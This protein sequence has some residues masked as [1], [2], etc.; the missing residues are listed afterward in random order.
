MVKLF[1]W[2]RRIGIAVIGLLLFGFFG[3]T[4]AMAEE[5]ISAESYVLMEAET[6]RV[7]SGRN[8]TEK[9][10]MAST[11][12][13]MTTLLVLEQPQLD[14]A[15]TVNS[16]EVKIEGSSMGLLPGDSVTLRDLCYGMMLPSGN[17]AANAAAVRIAGSTEEFAKMMNERAGEMGMESTNFVTPSGLHNEEHYST[18][19]DMALLAREALKNPDFSEIC[20]TAKAKRSFGNPP[21]QRWMTNHNK[22]LKYYEGCIGLKTGFTKKAGRCLVSAAEREG[23]TL[24]CVTLNAPSD[25]RDH[26]LLFDYG[27]SSVKQVMLTP[28]LTG[29]SLGIVGANQNTISVA[30]PEDISA[31]LTEEEKSR[32]IQKILLPQFVYAPV[33]EGDV[34][35]AVEYLLD[36]K[37][38]A[39]AELTAGESVKQKKVKVKLSRMEKIQNYVKDLFS[40]LFAR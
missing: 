22:L 23:V 29:V 27:F 36:G 5:K 1:D 16:E 11:T 33:A 18:A 4:T 12:K 32:I 40:P 8:E 9:R 19:Y 26:T 17:D 39:Q 37:K 13:I 20:R 6:G 24:V 28:D 30:A 34:V 2:K 21:Y 35:G 3:G 31:S 7:L 25:W 15:F 10:P 14:E 38:V